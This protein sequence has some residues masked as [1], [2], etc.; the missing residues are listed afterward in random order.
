MRI[1]LTLH[2]LAKPLFGCLLATILMS[3]LINTAIAQPA[4][5]G[6]TQEPPLMVKAVEGKVELYSTIKVQV[7]GLAKWVDQPGHDATKFILHIDGNPFADLT[8][9]ITDNDTML[10]FDLER[11]AENKHAWNDILGRYKRFTRQVPVTVRQEGVNVD[12]EARTTLIV[13]KRMELWIFVIVSLASL[14]LFWMLAR[15]SD[16]IREP[17]PQPQGRDKKGK[18]VRKPYSLGRTQMALWFFAIIISYVFI[19]L[20]TGDLASL[21]TSVLALMGISAGTGLGSAA[22]D[23]SKVSEQQ[24]QIDT[25]EEKKKNDEIEVEKLKTEI[26]ALGDALKATP[27]PENSDEQRATLTAKQSEL[28]AMQKEIEQTDQ[29]IMQLKD[30]MKPEV[31]ENFLLDILSDA[32]GVSFHRFQIFAWTIALICIFIAEVSDVLTMPEFDTTLLGLMGIS[33][34]TYIGFKIPNQQG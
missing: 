3:T 31:S 7:E 14:I 19:W 9:E 26:S 5:T 21:T 1:S 6:A 27:P 2:K 34:G 20:V 32:N 4:A 24:N 22:I 18:P 16:M 8:P 33:S 17:G 23:S 10:Q 15:R 12:G 28:A 29:K 13:I 30:A 25:L 11:T